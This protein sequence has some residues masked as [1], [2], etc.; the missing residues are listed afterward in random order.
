MFFNIDLPSE[1]AEQKFLP[2]YVMSITKDSITSEPVALNCSYI[3][4]MLEDFI[5]DENIV[6]TVSGRMGSGSF[7]FNIFN[8]VSLSYDEVSVEN[9]QIEIDGAFEG[10]RFL[11]LVEAK[12]NISSDFLVR[13]IYYPFRLWNERLQ[14]RKNIKLVYFVYT[15]GIFNFFEYVFDNP[16]NYNSIR[17]IKTKSYTLEDTSINLE[18]IQAIASA[19]PLVEEPDIP[20]PQA[21]DFR[22]IINLCELAVSNDLTKE[23]IALEYEF[24]IR[25]SDYYTNAC[26]YLGLMEKIEDIRSRNPSFKLSNDGRLMLKLSYIERQKY[27]VSKIVEHKTFKD[28]LNLALESGESPKTKDILPIMKSNK[29]YKV[30]TRNENSSTFLRRASSVRG[31]IEWIWSRINDV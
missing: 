7:I 23:S 15:N 19:T 16:S 30:G 29:L 22:K 10:D 31:W 25:Q 6:P 13:Q 24:N 12:Q 18:V 14:A 8:K 5:G 27:L 9:S 1:Q 4:G 2:G 3:S 21:D 26:R 20:F 17:L 11:T 28:A